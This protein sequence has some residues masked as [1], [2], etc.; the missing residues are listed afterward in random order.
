MRQLVK[1]EQGRTKASAEEA[2]KN[3]D[4]AKKLS[5]IEEAQK[6][7]EERLTGKV[8]KLEGDLKTASDEIARLTAAIEHGLGKDDLILLPRG[9]GAD[10]VSA[11]AK[12]LADRGGPSQQ[13]QPP[14]FDGGP[15]S[16]A[17]GSDWDTQMRD[18]MR[19]RR[20]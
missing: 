17:P 2:R 9:L 13:Q 19:N 11:A 5:E 20:R 7:T 8:G 18:A 3:A 15:R 4:A 14:D 1:T 12:R 10:D 6:S 16:K